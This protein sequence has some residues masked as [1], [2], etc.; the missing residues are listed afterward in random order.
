MEGS[1]S[2]LTPMDNKRHDLFWKQFPG[3]V[4]SNSKASDTVMIRA[5]LARPNTDRITRIAAYF[6][7]ERVEQERDVLLDDPVDPYSFIHISVV[8]RILESIKPESAYAH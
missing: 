6:G 3:L 2:F 7:I 8:N 5:A 4:W 1:L